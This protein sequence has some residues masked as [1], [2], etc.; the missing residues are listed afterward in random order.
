MEIEFDPAKN[1]ANIVKHGIELRF[2]AEVLADPFVV[3]HVDGRRDYGEM[4]FKALG[5][6]R[7]RVYALVYTEREHAQAG[8]GEAGIIRR[9]RMISVRKANEN[10]T[11]AYR[12]ATARR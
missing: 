10:E 7:G 5:A 4:R 6:V 8:V 11:T 2:G 12:Q 9:F 1:A 3:V